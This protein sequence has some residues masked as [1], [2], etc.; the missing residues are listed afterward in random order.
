MKADDLSPAFR[1]ALEDINEAGFAPPPVPCIAP[2][3]RVLLRT[4][5]MQRKVMEDRDANPS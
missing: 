4:I 1:Q 2:S 3:M 5:E